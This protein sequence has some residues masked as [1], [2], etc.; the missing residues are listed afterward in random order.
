MLDI[1][2]FKN[3][4]SSSQLRFI[5]RSSSCGENFEITQK[6]DNLSPCFQKASVPPKISEKSSQ[7][8]FEKINFTSSILSFKENFAIKTSSSDLK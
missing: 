8:L 5:R 3:R 2:A 1:S 6:S 4:K 7:N